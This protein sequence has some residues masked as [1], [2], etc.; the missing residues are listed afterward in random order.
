MKV[1]LL[2]NY[3]DEQALIAATLVR[4]GHDVSA[5]A[6]CE[7]AFA[8][9]QSVQ[10]QLLLL[11]PPAAASD[12][13]EFC[14]RVQSAGRIEATLVMVVMHSDDPH[15][16]RCED[17]IEAGAHDFILSPLE[18]RGLELRLRV[19]ERRIQI[20]TEQRLAEEAYR[21]QEYLNQVLLDAIPCPVFYK[22]VNGVYLACNTAYEKYQGFPKDQ[23]VGK[24]V[25]EM[26]PKDLAETYDARDRALLEQMTVQTYES[27]VV[28]ADGRRSFVLFY[29]APFRAKDGS[30]GGLVG[31][32]LDISQ[33]KETQA[34]LEEAKEQAEVA[35]RAKSAFIANMSHELRTP[36]NAIIGYSE[37]LQE[38]AE[39][40]ESE[41]LVPDLQK[42]STAGTH[43]LSLINA[44]LDLSKIEAGKMDLY[45]ETFEIAGILRDVTAVIKPVVEKNSNTLR[46]VADGDLGVMR[47]DLTKV[48]QSLFNLLSNASKFTEKGAIVL[49]V[50]RTPGLE[51]SDGS[52]YFRISD[53]GIGLT[54][55][56]MSRLFQEFTQADASTTRK[57]GGT[58]LG[59]ALSRR[60]CRMMGG[61][62]TVE[63]EY[64]VGSTFTIRLP[65]NVERARQVATPVETDQR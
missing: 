50:A 55:E 26:W 11:G 1:L 12:I 38:E 3:L 25:Y 23:L 61:D 34:A 64:G 63:S 56:Q 43:L 24:T 60:F 36:L 29:K 35:N 6:R 62:I 22:D 17:A 51:G 48:R 37:M 47:A 13:A 31:T 10:Y 7:D 21:N 41:S 32:I 58:G 59:L 33:L 2:H 30:V 42:I 20:E 16:L 46:V 4:L 19:L 39:D 57:Y 49:E 15:A 8:A 54:E 52:V 45:L 14:R 18:P 65:A 9:A 5:Y 44:V 28:D 53:S 40:F 27:S